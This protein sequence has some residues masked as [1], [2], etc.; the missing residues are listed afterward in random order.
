MHKKER[1]F[2]LLEVFIALIILALIMSG[3]ANVFIAVKRLTVHSRSRAQSAELGRLV[4]SP[5]QMDVDQSGW[6][7]GTNDY[8]SPNNLRK[9]GVGITRPGTPLTLNSIEYKPFYEVNVPPD[10]ASTD[11]MRK[12]KVTITWTEPSAQ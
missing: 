8:N 2:S 4:L 9:T 5:L 1:G 7:A 12:V 11:A 10:F 6:N 3:L